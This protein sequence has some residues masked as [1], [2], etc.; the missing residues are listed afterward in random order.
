MS[1][2]LDAN[3]PEGPIQDK[4][5][6]H[7]FKCKVVNP[8]NKRKYSVNINYYGNDKGISEVVGLFNS[9]AESIKIK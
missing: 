9:I 3:I 6:S 1:F 2:K 4:W 5:E 8:S 7:K